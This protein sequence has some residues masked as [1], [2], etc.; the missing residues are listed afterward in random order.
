L[1]VFGYKKTHF[2]DSEKDYITI[3]SSSRDLYFDGYWHSY[4]YF[5]EYNSRLLDNLKFNVDLED[6]RISYLVNTIKS[7]PNAVSIHVRQGDYLTIKS[8]INLLI[9]NYYNDCLKRI[10]VR[11]QSVFVFSDDLN[12]IRKNELLKNMCL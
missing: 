7:D 9:T 10:F 12:A 6:Q 8:Y 5:S 3:S 4:K 11:N 1:R 2:R